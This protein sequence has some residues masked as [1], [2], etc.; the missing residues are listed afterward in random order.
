M[1]MGSHR[2]LSFSNFYLMSLHFEP[3]DWST[4]RDVVLK[5]GGAVGL[6]CRRLGD[7]FCVADS[8]SSGWMV[9][10]PV[11]L[12]RVMG[13]EDALPWSWYGL[14]TNLS[15]WPIVPLSL[16]CHARILPG[17]FL[18]HWFELPIGLPYFLTFGNKFDIKYF[19]WCIAMHMMHACMTQKYEMTCY[20]QKCLIDYDLMYALWRQGKHISN[21]IR[22]LQIFL[23]SHTISII[24]YLNK[25]FR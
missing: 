18:W 4:G 14:Q 19:T 15:V 1:R 20:A 17:C 16:G 11:S 24:F 7:Q 8:S 25:H 13:L 21:L 12:T 23:S 10:R 9:E 3:F 6:G 5:V 2:G 22:F